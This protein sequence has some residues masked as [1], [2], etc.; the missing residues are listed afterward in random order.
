MTIDLNR[1][2]L[3]ISMSPRLEAALNENT[4]LLAQYVKEGEALLAKLPVKAKRNEKE[5][6]LAD[7]IF[8][9][10]RQLRS[11]FIHQHAD[12]VYGIL[13]ENFSQYR[14]ISELVF[15]A[16][17]RFPGLVPT[18]AQMET[19]SKHIQ[20][21]KD[22]LEIDQ[23]IFFRGLL[24][25]SKVGSHLMDAML[26][27]TPRALDLL[28]NLRHAN[29]IDL[30]S[31]LF[32]R[33]QQAAYLTINNQHSLNAEDNRLI[34]DLEIAVDLALLDER[35]KVCILRGG[36]MTHPRYLGKR[37]FCAGIN[38]SDLHSGKISFVNFLLGRE[39]GY[40]SKIAHGLLMDPAAQTL[41]ERTVQKPWIAAIDSFAIGGG[42]QLM[43]VF[44]KIIAADDAYFS[45]P[46]AQEGIVP[47]AANF[48]LPQIAGNRL[49]RQI[50]LSG[51]KIFA[52]DPQA[53]CLCDEVV[54]ASEIDASI[55][56]AIREFENPAVRENR[57][58]LSL[59][60]WSQAEFREYMAEF[61]YIQ[62]MRMNSLDVLAKIGRWARSQ[63]GMNQ[64]KE[65]SQCS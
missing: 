40:I 5:Q 36:V 35:V 12:E 42:M 37:V 1:I 3:W 39:L 32:E 28:E 29:K 60:E 51:R 56:V 7:Q 59:A 53:E 22:G 21:H 10:C 17:Q 8:A 58:M 11:R 49:T 63:P 13:T 57:R 33:R 2:D 50:I 48:R 14:R 24:H 30:G 27:P 15:D 64:A 25:S 34:E 62:A 38:L 65:L 23:G 41:L 31:I 55:E 19:E 46:A 44:D 61:A 16:A 9:S 6:C 52:S 18:R 45:L 4:Y 20:A 26:L 47:G 43:L 54:P